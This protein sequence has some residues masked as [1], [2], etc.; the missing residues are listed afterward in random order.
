MID[1]W[2]KDLSHAARSLRKNAG[3]SLV[4][5]VTIALGIGACTAIF[6]V[7]NAVLL[8]PLPYADAQRLVLVWG[9]LRAR[10]VQDWP[11]SP[12]DLRDLQQQSTEIFDDIA[13]MIPAGRVP[14]AGLG[15]EPEQIRV[16]GATPNLFRL[17]GAH[18]VAGRDFVAD[19]AIPPP[20]VPNQ[21]AAQPQPPVAAILSHAF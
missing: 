8:R 16:G 9:E 1:T 21:A 7:V 4:A 6:S 5:T 17:L 12:P 15:Q 13:G 18:V 3:F 19:D 10:N 11:F 20:A 2:I 14:I